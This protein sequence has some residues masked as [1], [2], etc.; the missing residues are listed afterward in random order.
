MDDVLVVD[1][2]APSNAYATRDELITRFGEREVNELESMHDDGVKATQDALSDASEEMDSYLSVR[3]RVPLA[4]TKHL[5]IICCNIARYRLWA[6]DASD[7]VETRYK[8]A[9][10]WLEAVAKSKANVTF[11]E[12]LTDEEEQATHIAP[13]VPIGD[14]YKGSVFGD[15]VFATMPNFGNKR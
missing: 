14:S 1:A 8:D 15:D 9:I 7:E 3:Y 10:K 11:A 2:Q 4:K 13:A 6:F 12:E 5:K